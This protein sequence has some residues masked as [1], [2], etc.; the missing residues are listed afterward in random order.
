MTPPEWSENAGG[1]T[2]RE[3][4]A[5]RVCRREVSDAIRVN[6]T[7]TEEAEP[8][9]GE[10]RDSLNEGE[11]PTHDAIDGHF[12]TDGA[13]ENSDDGERQD[14][15]VWGWLAKQRV[16]G[17]QGAS[18]EALYDGVCES[19]E[20]DFSVLYP[21]LPRWMQMLPGNVNRKTNQ[22]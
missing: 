5:C 13:L 7:N 12:E 9:R 8:P 10:S 18:D 15:R 3:S 1:V 20:V 11:P 2:L 6:S 17:H 16:T 19:T 21:P 22:A 14:D 4:P